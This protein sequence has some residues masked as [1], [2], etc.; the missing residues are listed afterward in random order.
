M[1]NEAAD[2]A[3]AASAGRGA[4]AGGAPG[5]TYRDRIAAFLEHPGRAAEVARHLDVSRSR[6][7]A[8]LRQM[9]AAGRLRRL[10]Y[11]LY[12]AA[13]PVP[14]APAAVQQRQ[15]RLLAA[16]D[17]PRTLPDAATTAGL[18]YG[19][20]AAMRVLVKEERAVQLGGGLYGK[21][22]SFPAQP[23]ATQMPS[24]PELLRALQ[25]P[26][27]AR[28]LAATF[29]VPTDG[30][31]SI[32]QRC[33]AEG[34]VVQAGYRCYVATGPRGQPPR[35]ARTPLR[36]QP[37]RDAILAFMTEP[38]QAH[39]VAVHIGGTVSLATGHLR[40][41]LSRFILPWHEPALD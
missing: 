39:E 10:G 16:L 38:R 40:A 27:S 15:A 11:G 22:A 33:E 26:Q 18:P 17:R 1:L 6:A 36:P 4:D 7:S 30:L 34:L 21:T 2:Q 14:A 25:E 12:C 32:L 24:L 3:E 35:P 5:R 28:T 9:A 29:G 37:V 23:P 19:A 31:A 41:C 20:H 8:M 13:D